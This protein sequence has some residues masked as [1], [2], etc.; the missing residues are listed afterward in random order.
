MLLHPFTRVNFP[1]VGV[2]S[3]GLANFSDSEREL[4]KGKRLR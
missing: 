4:E 1:V 2:P 3:G